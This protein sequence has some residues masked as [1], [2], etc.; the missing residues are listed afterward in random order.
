MDKR[1]VCAAIKHP[2]GRIVC[3][4]RHYDAA[5]I[6][7][8]EQLPDMWTPGWQAAEQGFIDQRCEFLTREEAWKIADTN[9]QIIRERDWA[10]G[11]LHSEHLY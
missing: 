2:D 3:G 5:M 4:A 11:S 10:T 1:V 6:R 7:Q 9:G 8:L